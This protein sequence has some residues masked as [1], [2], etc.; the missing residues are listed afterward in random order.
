MSYKEKKTS[1]SSP[2]EGA[3]SIHWVCDWQIRS[4]EKQA[5]CQRQGNGNSD[6]RLRCVQSTEEWGLDSLLTGRLL[7]GRA[8]HE[9]RAR[10]VL[11]WCLPGGRK[12]A[13][14]LESS[15]AVT[16]ETAYNSILSSKGSTGGPGSVSCF[17]SL[18]GT[19]P[20]CRAPSPS[21]RPLSCLLSSHHLQNHLRDRP[22]HR[23]FIFLNS[24]LPNNHELPN[25]PELFHQVEAAANRLA[26]LPLR[27]H[28]PLSLERNRRQ[29]RLELRALALPA[30]SAVASWRAT[31][32][33]A[34]PQA[35]LG[36]CL[37]ERLAL[38]LD[39]EP[40]EPRGLRGSPL[41]PPEGKLLV[42]WITGLVSTEAHARQRRRHPG[43]PPK[44][45]NTELSQGSRKEET[46]PPNGGTHSHK[47]T[48][49][50]PL[51]P[52]GQQA[53]STAVP[54][55]RRVRP[56][57]TPASGVLQSPQPPSRLGPARGTGKPWMVAAQPP[58]NTRGSD[59]HSGKCEGS[60]VSAAAPLSGRGPSKAWEQSACLLRRQA[61]QK[62]P[63]SWR[64]LKG[65]VHQRTGTQLH[66]EK[67]KRVFHLQIQPSNHGSKITHSSHSGGVAMV[68]AA[69]PP[70]VW[71]PS[72]CS[73]D[74][75][76]VMA[77]GAQQAGSSGA[78]SPDTSHVTIT[79]TPEARE[80]E[81]PFQTALRVTRSKNIQ[82][83]P[84]FKIP[85]QE[86]REDNVSRAFE[87]LAL[88]AEE[89]LAMVMI[90]TLVTAVQEKF[91]KIGGQIKT[92]REEKKQ[93]DM[94]FLLQLRIS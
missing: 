6:S 86:S 15:G 4:W 29:A 63:L 12:T 78:T 48:A 46:V 20:G 74:T 27:L 55:P 35:G 90:F 75:M 43:T 88:Q 40:W 52:A 79:V 72:G 68:P 45:R 85:S 18:D 23:V 94:A 49:P 73:E 66:R 42:S 93:T 41:H 62:P 91:N 57:H 24:S 56:L 59:S 44:A 25:P 71:A 58:R 5:A 47:M 67:R 28:T 3:V 14:N 81:E 64:L 83:K 22:T 38:K 69:G 33:A 61:F 16:P 37:F 32:G 65:L 84:P 7:R 8:P 60:Q 2:M 13:L 89:N 82:V 50:S 1:V 53:R 92:R 30:Q 10:G 31:S 11:S 70:D 77:R 17:S 26:S 9:G 87:L 39:Q 21:L 36:E 54:A 51:S 19:D 80:S 76:T 34:G